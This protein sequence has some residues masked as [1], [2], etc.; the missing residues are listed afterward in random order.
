MYTGKLDRRRRLLLRTSAAA[1]VAVPLAGLVRLSPARAADGKPLLSPD[2]PAA[3][4]LNYHADASEAPADQRE[5][6]AFCRNC[7]FFKGE[8]D[9]A[10][11][12]GCVIFPE[13]RVN[14]KGWCQSWR[15]A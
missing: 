3:E 15:A 10:D 12:G 13:N 5:G 8:R 11:A 2:D 7:T 6:N 4:R 1:A 9:S 14:A